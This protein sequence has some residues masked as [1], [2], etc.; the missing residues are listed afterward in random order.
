MKKVVSV[1]AILWVAVAAAEDSWLY[2][3][4]G[5]TGDYTLGA[6][7][8][9]VRVRGYDE[10]GV[11]EY[12]SLYYDSSTVVPEAYSGADHKALN[13]DN[14]DISA[15]SSGVGLYAYLA[16]SSAY[17]SFVIELFNDSSFV[18]ASESLSI[19]SAKA[20][21]ESGNSIT[22]AN[23]WVGSSY[24]IPEPNSAM[25]LL[26]GCAALCLKRRKIK[27]A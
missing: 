4:V 27:I 18:A 12:L 2:W 19:A 25:L 13:N 17:S 26:V 8:N 3:M 5:D 6:S 7:Y 21:I 14:Y 20:Y 16:S 1:L 22:F 23:A 10:N 9:T 11:G 15:M 24:A